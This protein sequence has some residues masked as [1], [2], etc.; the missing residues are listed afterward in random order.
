M[1]A[2]YTHEVIIR[3]KIDGEWIVLKPAYHS[4]FSRSVYEYGEVPL[5]HYEVNLEDVDKDVMFKEVIKLGYYPEDFCGSKTLFKKRIYVYLYDY[6]TRI[7]K[8]KLGGIQVEHKYY[9]AKNPNIE[10]LKKDLRFNGYSQLV[11]D[12][13]QELKKMLEE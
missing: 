7:Y 1:K 12:R 8:D 4:M 10:W 11:F 6:D 3:L 2:V 5:D 13:E 9:I